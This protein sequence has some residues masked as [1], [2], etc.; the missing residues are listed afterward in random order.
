MSVNKGEIHKFMVCF[1]TNFYSRKLCKNMSIYSCKT[2]DFK[3]ITFTKF[4]L[5]VGHYKELNYLDSHQFHKNH[6]ILNSACSCG[7]TYINEVQKICL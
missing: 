2:I 3:A 7:T 4:N 1:S 6:R 5:N